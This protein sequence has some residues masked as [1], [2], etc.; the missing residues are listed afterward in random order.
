MPRS[1]TSAA[2]MKYNAVACARKCAAIFL[3]AFIAIFLTGSFSEIGSSAQAQTQ[4]Q[5]Q[6]TQSPVGA[7][8]G[9]D[10]D[11]DM[12]RAVKRGDRGNVSI[13]DKKSGVLIQSGGQVFRDVRN[14]PVFTYGAV[15]I[16]G[17]IAVLS[18]FYMLRGRIRIDTGKSDVTIT[19]FN[20]IER[21]AHWLVAGS[22]V[23]LGLSGLN[24]IYGKFL[25]TP[26]VG[27]SGYAEIAMSGKWLHNFVAFAFIL[28]LVLI[29]LMWIRHN[30]PNRHDI[31]WILKGGGMFTRGTHPPAKKF[32]AG[33]KILFWM[34]ILG[35][36][37]ISL[38]GISLMFPFQL[39]LFAD[40]FEIINRLGFNL[41]TELT[42]IE[43]MQLA[44]VWHSVASIVMICV[45]IAHIYIGTV[46]MEGAF[47]AMG[48]G[49]VDKN[50]AKEH[51][52][53]WVEELESKERAKAASKQVAAE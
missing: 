47:D 7:P 42:G 23:I 20:S 27:K 17:F 29:L 44:L 49:E 22:F 21:F 25:L 38:S 50:W 19:R 26:L 30:F 12:W 36:A 14:G 9:N 52:S 18:L 13:T 2:T 32:N 48:S 11:S 53:I 46:G 31:I 45:I 4:T 24:M 39:S 43:E 28:G 6:N 34:I 41:P 15:A 1:T 33:Q 3:L 37:S 8:L 10:S 51:H 5:A 40:T 35:G 16:F